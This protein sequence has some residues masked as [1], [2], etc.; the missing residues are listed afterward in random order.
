MNLFLYF[1]RITLSSLVN[2][3]VPLFVAIVRYGEGTNTW[4]AKGFMAIGWQFLFLFAA[5]RVM[6]TL[7]S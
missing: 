1:S 4:L 2:F 3:W 7:P 5:K 6:F